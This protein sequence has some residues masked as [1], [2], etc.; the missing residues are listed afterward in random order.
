MSSRDLIPYAP[1]VPTNHKPGGRYKEPSETLQAAQPVTAEAYAR[2]W[3]KH[4][5]IG[6][7]FHHCF[8]TTEWSLCWYW[9]Y[10][11]DQEGRYMMRLRFL[12]DHLN[13]VYG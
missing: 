3:T 4:D 10:F 13:D 5:N 12:A 1:P 11:T 8:V 2:A 6:G 9:Q 7:S